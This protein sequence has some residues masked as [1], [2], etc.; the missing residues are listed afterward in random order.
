MLLREEGVSFQKVKTF[1]RSKDPDYAVKKARVEHLYAIADGEVVPD[2]GEPQVIFCLDEFGPLNLQ[3][4]PG[5]QWAE[6]GGKHKD[7]DREPGDLHPSARGGSTCSPPTTWARIGST[8][9]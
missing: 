3:P 2:S 5:R 8:G 6:R 4:H 9:T 1:K 7:P